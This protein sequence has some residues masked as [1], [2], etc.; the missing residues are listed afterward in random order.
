MLST[1]TLQK[2]LRRFMV[3]SL[4]FAASNA[5]ADSKRKQCT[6]PPGDSAKLGTAYSVASIG[7]LNADGESDVLVGY[8]YPLENSGRGGYAIYSAKEGTVLFSQVS[9]RDFAQV[10]TAVTGIGDVNADGVSDYVVT[11]VNDVAGTGAV[12]I[13][14]GASH[15]EICSTSGDPSFVRFGSHISRIADLNADGA[16]DLVVAD[17]R[18]YGSDGHIITISG[19]NCVTLNA[20]P[21]PNLSGSISVLSDVDGDSLRDFAVGRVYIASAA[22]SSEGTARR[23]SQ[24]GGFLVLSSK[25]G[26]ILSSGEDDDEVY[27]RA[28]ASA[29]DV[30]NDGIVDFFLASRTHIHLLSGKDGSQLAISTPFTSSVD[31]NTM[32]SISDINADGFTDIELQM[33]GQDI[34]SLGSFQS[35]E[36]L[37]GRT[38]ERLD[39]RSLYDSGYPG[40]IGTLP[41]ANGAPY[42]FF[43]DG[44]AISYPLDNEDTSPEIKIILTPSLASHGLLKAAVISSKANGKCQAKIKLS[45]NAEN[46]SVDPVSLNGL[47][48]RCGNSKAVANTTVARISVICEGKIL[49][50]KNSRLKGSSP[51]SRQRLNRVGKG[52]TWK[53]IY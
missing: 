34:E 29:S 28:L 53:R 39:V 24:R 42:T 50:A 49:A 17:A 14:S 1:M 41:R 4:L 38:L 51:R 31:M 3:L 2:L 35:L 36:R 13:L 23:A 19:K 47:A 33:T 48:Y 40:V 27:G 32:H 46:S 44:S 21:V 16:D 43:S 5:L 10:G 18:F 25:T 22:A 6:P 37:N 45:S 15:A 52:F 30:N 26:A 8:P 9:T 11:E 20:F 12:H 7:D